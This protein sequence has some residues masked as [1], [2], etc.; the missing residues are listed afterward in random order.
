MGQ[1][2]EN[3]R[4]PPRAADVDAAPDERGACGGRPPVLLRAVAVLGFLGGGVGG[5]ELV[6]G[7]L[8]LEGRLRC[9]VC[10]ITRSERGCRGGNRTCVWSES[11]CNTKRPAI[12]G[13]SSMPFVQ[14]H[15]W[16]KIELL[17]TTAIPTS[18]S[19]G[20]SVRL[21][22]IPSVHILPPP[23]ARRCPTLKMRD[24]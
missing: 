7:A 16:P 13:N 21:S 12:K 22:T 20:N 4:V 14:M 23:G 9:T 18:G 1:G 15:R 6:S 8:R 5:S 17:G 10:A 19:S 11:C 3:T 2:I 24:H